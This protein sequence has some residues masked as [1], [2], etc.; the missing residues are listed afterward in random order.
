MKKKEMSIKVLPIDI[1]K[2]ITFLKSFPK[3]NKMTAND[4]NNN[5]KS[6]LIKHRIVRQNVKKELF[7][8]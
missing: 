4:N 1:S 2:V 6:P 8:S 5:N 7:Q 3:I